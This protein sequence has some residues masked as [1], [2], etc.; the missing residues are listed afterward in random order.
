MGQMMNSALERWLHL[1]LRSQ[2][3]IVT[4]CLGVVA[5]MLGVLV[6]R[7]QR[8][9]QQAL[10][11]DLVVLEQ[12]YQQRQAQLNALPNEALLRSQLAELTRDS[13]MSSCRS[14]L[15]AVL[16]AHGS[17]LEIWQPESDPSIL[18]LQ[19][20]WPQFQ[21]LFAELAEAATPF[22]VRFLLETQQGRLQASLWLE[23]QD[24]H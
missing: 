18:T 3:A 20:A 6:V 22:P 10:R 17:Q 21:P 11:A 5:L 23:N 13:D 4:V 15:E 16:A 9:A 2:I 14:S 24:A 8:L 1:S 12:Q 19:L 7:P